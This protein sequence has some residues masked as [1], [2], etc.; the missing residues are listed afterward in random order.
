VECKYS[1]ERQYITTGVREILAYAREYPPRQH[2]QR[3]HVVI[4]PGGVVPGARSWGGEL[5]IGTPADLS[6]L[7][8]HLLQGGVETLLAEWA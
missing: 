5:A 1:T 4:G 3:I 2:V 7:V 8:S 6:G